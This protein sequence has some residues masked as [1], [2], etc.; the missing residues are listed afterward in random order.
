MSEPVVLPHP[1]PVWP[2]PAIVAVLASPYAVGLGVIHQLGSTD[3]HRAL[4]LAGGAFGIATLALLTA[5]GRASRR[6]F[7]YVSADGIRLGSPTGRVVP[8]GSELVLTGAVGRAQ[9]LSTQGFVVAEMLPAPGAFQTL[10]EQARQCATLLGLPLVDRRD[11]EGWQ[12]WETDPLYRSALEF[13]ER[14]VE[15][16]R[17]A[18]EMHELLSRPDGTEDHAGARYTVQTSKRGEPFVL[19]TTHLEHGGRAF[20]W[21]AVRDAAVMVGDLQ[22]RLEILTD[23]GEVCLLSATPDPATMG[24]LSFLAERIRESAGRATRDLGSATDVPDA[25]GSLRAHREP[26]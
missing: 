9:H 2:H 11:S 25:L 20:R 23:E 12:A 21:D 1:R 3:L 14:A 19:T 22:I 8:L 13:R 26:G 18:P 7:A 4:L 24:Q 6:A 17:R 5:H 15:S 16:E 10:T